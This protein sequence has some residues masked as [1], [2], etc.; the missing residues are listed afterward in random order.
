MRESW[1]DEKCE[2]KTEWNKFKK[3]K[4][5]GRKR[6]WLMMTWWQGCSNSVVLTAYQCL[7]SMWLKFSWHH[8]VYSSVF[9]LHHCHDKL[10]TQYSNKPLQLIHHDADLL[11][12]NPFICVVLAVFYQTHF[13]M[14]NV[15]LFDWLGVKILHYLLN[16]WVFPFI[17]TL[18][19]VVMH[20][21][22]MSFKILFFLI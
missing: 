11:H 5:Q 16:C 10:I 15:L 19:N 7:Q 9:L 17:S 3:E 8:C 13:L 6:L 12:F 14:A 20:Y 2:R 18:T 22:G 1:R 4:R 21:N